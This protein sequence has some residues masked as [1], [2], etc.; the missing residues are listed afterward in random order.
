MRIAFFG[1]YIALTTAY[2]RN[3]YNLAKRLKARGHE[4]YVSQ[5]PCEVCCVAVWD[6]WLEMNPERLILEGHILHEI[7]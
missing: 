5:P 1:D 7:A 4:V 6:T 3:I 2:G